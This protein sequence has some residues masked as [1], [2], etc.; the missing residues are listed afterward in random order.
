MEPVEKYDHKG[1]K[2]RIYYDDSP[3]STPRD[4]SNVGTMVC[5]HRGYELGDRPLES[6][7]RK[8]LERG[9]MHL[10]TRYLTMWEGATV[11]IPLGL[12]DHSG[13][14]MYAGGGAHVMDPGGW[15]SG[16]V[17]FIFDTPAGR[18]E[19][20]TPLD[21]IEEIL[22]EEIEVYDQYLTGDV[23]GYIVGSGEHEESCWGFYGMDDVKQEAE[24]IAEGI[25]HDLWVEEEPAQDVPEIMAVLR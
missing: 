21:R 2:I 18:E 9:G 8:A 16:T 17:G 11:V 15:D 22:H 1:V 4:W 14:S 23:Y 5:W 3:A 10:L 7:E 12:I 13:I 24:S 25:A 6:Q 20:G 19:C